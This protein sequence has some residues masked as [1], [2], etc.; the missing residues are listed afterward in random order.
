M[1][2]GSAGEGNTSISKERKSVWGW[3]NCLSKKGEENVL[4]EEERLTPLG[5]L[6]SRGEGVWG[7]FR[8]VTK[9]AQR[10]PPLAPK[11]RKLGGALPLLRGA[12]RFGGDRRGGEGGAL[13][14]SRVSRL[15]LRGEIYED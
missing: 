1:T 4:Y 5:K 10:A 8:M 2:P 12:L 15:R 9:G 7:K 11:K 13:A 3:Q 14:K 6:R